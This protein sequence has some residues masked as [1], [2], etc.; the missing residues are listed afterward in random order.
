[1]SILATPIIA[2]HDASHVR[3]TG[4]DVE[5]GRGI[6]I[7]VSG[8]SDNQVSDCTVSNMGTVGVFVSGGSDQ[9]VR[10]C[11]VSETGEGGMAVI[12][13]N[14]RTLEPS[15][16]QISD[17]RITRSN[18]WLKTHR[19]AIRIDGVGI[20]VSHNAIRDLPDTAV[21]L[22]G[23]DNTVE[24][25]DIS[26]VCLDSSDVGA[27]YMG[28]DWSERGNVV[29]DNYFHDIGSGRG[30]ADNRDVMAVYLDDFTSG[31]LVYGNVF[32]RAGVG[33]FIGG[34]RDNTVGNNLFVDCVTGVRADA[35]GLNWAKSYI[36][37]TVPTLFD[38]LKAMAFDMPPY[39]DRYPTLAN[40][41]D[42][43]PGVPK[44]N[45]IT[46]NVSLG[47]TWLELRDG[48]TDAVIGISRN[49]VPQAAEAGSL[50]NSDFELARGSPAFQLGFE[51]IPFREIG[52]RESREQ[53]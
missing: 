13:G 14:R 15:R 47:G 35:R 24:Y 43:E 48:L 49:Y 10:G 20:T 5:Y 39:S 28:R 26:A 22:N 30:K 42:D 52:P 18:R 1:M 31:T 2:L 6:G 44:G 17:N 23:N 4:I 7:E 46:R 19:P 25:N 34:G 38:R 32:F 3:L 16:D 27:F 9:A 50:V 37:G 29:R 41:L 33:V 45:S 8:G 11:H 36:D 53:P 40:I 21:T 51:P 12:G